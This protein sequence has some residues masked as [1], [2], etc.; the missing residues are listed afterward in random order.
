MAE[1]PVTITVT[2]ADSGTCVGGYVGRIVTNNGPTY[3]SCSTTISGFG[4]YGTVNAVGAT[5]GIIAG[6]VTMTGAS[7]TNGIMIGVDDNYNRVRFAKTVA[8]V[9]QEGVTLYGD[10]STNQ[11]LSTYIAQI[12][13]SN[14]TSKKK[15]DGTSLKGIYYICAKN[16][17]T[18]AEFPYG[19]NN[20]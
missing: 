18:E 20:Y 12:T 9:R 10:L 5:A 14:E 16:G 15:S 4:M 3:P 8:L 2:G 19:F 7:S 17:K 13:P 1:D 6:N 11:D